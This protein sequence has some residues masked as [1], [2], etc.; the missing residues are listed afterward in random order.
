M[1]AWCTPRRLSYL[2]TIAL[3]SS[4]TLSAEVSFARGT[5]R[6]FRTSFVDKDAT[7]RKRTTTSRN[8]PSLSFL[9][10]TCR[11]GAFHLDEDEYDNEYDNEEEEDETGV[12]SSDDA[13]PTALSSVVDT[14]NSISQAIMR[15]LGAASKSL[16]SEDDK[17][18]VSFVGK[19]FQTIKSMISAAL[20]PDYDN[21]PDYQ[22]AEEDEDDSSADDTPMEV[23][24]KPL[25]RPVDLGSYLAQSYGAPDGRKDATESPIL[26]GSLADALRIARS[27]AKLLVVMIPST[28]PNKAKTKIDSQAITSFLSAQVAKVA[29][30]KA[31]KK[32]ETTSYLLWSAKAGSSEAAMAM[33]RL[34][35]KATSSKGDK[36]PILLVA[37]PVQV[38][39]SP[40]DNSGRGVILL[41]M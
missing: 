12:Q 11:G 34:K 4:T 10:R 13:T 31:R 6:N 38:S 40:G 27:S 29:K 26:G 24:S 19:V 2:F 3:I 37:Y 20:N 5:T 22:E 1:K 36:R 9:T 25:P 16:Q 32:G 35:V 14:L 17:K 21:N 7:L 33:K 23:K 28:A 15:A 41:S 18:E 8:S 39:K 30:K